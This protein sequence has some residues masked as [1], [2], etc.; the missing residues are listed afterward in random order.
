MGDPASG[1]A[2]AAH[3]MRLGTARTAR[4]RSCASPLAAAQPI[5]NPV[6]LPGP[7]PTTSPCT[8]RSLTPAVSSAWSTSLMICAACWRAPRTTTTLRVSSG[9]PTATLAMSVAVSMASQRALIPGPPHPKCGV[10]N[11]ECGMC[12]AQF[13]TRSWPL[14]SNPALQFRIPH[15]ALRT[16]GPL[17]CPSPYLLQLPNVWCVPVAQSKVPVQRRRPGAR[18]LGPLDQDDGPLAH[19]VVEAQV[20]G[21]VGRAEAIAVDVVDRRAARLVVV[22]ERVG[23]TR[24]ERLRSQ[25]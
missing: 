16:H 25:P 17:A 1:A 6:K 12:R 13:R 9:V 22:Y 11:V 23:G 5:R 2:P 3:A 19:H 18:A 14:G 20:L 7:S 8:S 15:S 24:R 10:R 4:P 21:L